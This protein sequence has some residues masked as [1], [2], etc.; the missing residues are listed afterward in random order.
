LSCGITSILFDWVFDGP[1][2]RI[3]QQPDVITIEY[4]HG[5]ARTIDMTTDEHP[6]GIEPSRAG[7]S[8]GRW[9]GDTLVVHTI[10]FLPGSLA[11]AVPHSGELAVTERF[12]LD[13]A[14]FALHRAYVAEDPAYFTGE[15][16]GEDTVLP[17]DAPFAVDDCKELAFEYRTDDAE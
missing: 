8:I 2:N 1:V 17:A 3:T 10:G 6:A 11:G 13:P 15:Y 16:V 9:D 14:T 5:L 4:G 7:H 12:T